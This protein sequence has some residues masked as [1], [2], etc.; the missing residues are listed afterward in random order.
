MILYFG[1]R[2]EC[3]FLVLSGCE[4]DG[5]NG[6]LDWLVAWKMHAADKLTPKKE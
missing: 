5:G 6:M 4:V 1:S 3:E 2:L